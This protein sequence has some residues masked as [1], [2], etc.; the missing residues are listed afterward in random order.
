MKQTVVMVLLAG[1]AAAAWA[2]P[3]LDGKITDG[4]YSVVQAK[5]GFTLAARLSADGSTLH[6]AVS[7]ATE[8]WIAVGIGTM[9]MNGSFMIMGLVSEGKPSISFE[10]GKGYSH[11]PT[12]A[13]GASAVVVES[14]GMTILEVVLP[15][16]DYVRDGKLETI[17]AAGTRDDFRTK[18]ARRTALE[19]TL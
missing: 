2:Q 12:P 4:E 6:V 16:K 3:V 19:L 9:R 14:G 1:L 11:A 13:P 18:H 15:A 7:T 5:D 8:G 10:L 17:A